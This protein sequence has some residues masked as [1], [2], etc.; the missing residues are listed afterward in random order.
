MKFY[1][2]LTENFLV[3]NCRKQYRI[4]VLYKYGFM[5]TFH[6]IYMLSCVFD[7]VDLFNSNAFLFLLIIHFCLAVVGVMDDVTTPVHPGIR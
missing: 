3:N 4:I 2:I 5:R 7:L 6:I 1:H